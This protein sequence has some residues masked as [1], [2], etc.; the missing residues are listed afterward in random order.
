MVIAISMQKLDAKFAGLADSY[1]LAAL[2]YLVRVM[3]PMNL[4][5]LQCFALIAQYSLVTPTRTASYWIVGLAS[6]LCQEL[7]VTEEAT[8]G[9]VSKRRPFDAL[10]MDMRRRLFWIIASM[11]MGLAHSLARPSAFGASCDHVNVKFF[12][13]VD[14]CFISSRGISTQCPLSNKKQ[15]AIHFMSMRLL[16]AEMRRKLYLK[17]RLAPNDDRDP[18]FVAMQQKLRDWLSRTPEDAEGSG[19]DHTWYVRFSC[20]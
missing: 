16:Q 11:E 8:I 4:D 17:K 3:E 7:G 13:V 6:R 14:D 1:Y 15:F 19:L 9:L 12:E 2:P 18:W 20:K 10:E 5:T